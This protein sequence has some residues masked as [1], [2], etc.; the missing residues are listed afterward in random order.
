[1]QI[2]N[3]RILTAIDMLNSSFLAVRSVVYFTV[4]EKCGRS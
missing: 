3:L 1:M 2:R 4:I